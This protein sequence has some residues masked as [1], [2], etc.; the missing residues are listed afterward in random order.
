MY[1]YRRILFGTMVL[2]G[3]IFSPF[4]A[5]QAEASY[6]PTG[7]EIAGIR[8]HVGGGYGGRYG[9]WGPYRGGYYR[10]PGYYRHHRWGPYRGGYLY[11]RYYYSSPNYY[12][13]YYYYRYG[14]PRGGIYFRW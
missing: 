1:W 5:S 13:N 2:V 12:D 8:V 14:K 6:Q 10:Y 9:R 4:S 11:P 3:M 7:E